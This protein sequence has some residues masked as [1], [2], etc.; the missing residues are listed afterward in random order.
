LSLSVLKNIKSKSWN[1]IES[2][3]GKV[4]HAPQHSVDGCSSPSP[5]PWVHRWKTTCGQDLPSHEASPRIGWY[6]IILL[7]DRGTMGKH[8]I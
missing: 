4:D 6:Q 8:V 1:C 5:R 7:G 2:G 3:K